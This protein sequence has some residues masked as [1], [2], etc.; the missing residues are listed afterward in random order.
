M[1]KK[2]FFLV[3]L[4]FISLAGNAQK[5]G[6][7]LSGGG[8]KGLTHIG[9]IRALEENGIPID[10]VSG[11]S[12]GAII[13]SLYAMGYSPDEMDEILGSEDFKRWYTGQVEDEYKY[14]FK[15]N[16]PTPEFFS[17]RFGM[18]AQK[19]LSPTGF[20]SM[21]NPIQMNL[22][23]MDLFSRATATCKGNF[24]DL[25]VP[26]RCVASDI[27]N[28]R[29]MILRNGDLGDAVRASMSF[30]FVFKPII[31]NGVKA[32]DGG[33]Y[34]NFP[35]DVM[36]K[37]FHPD[38]ILG[39]VVA[40]DYSQ[41]EE[42]DIMGQMESM[43]MQ[44]T[45]YDIPKKE[46]IVLKFKYPD[47]GLM[48][49]DKI[50][51]LE[52]IGYDS[53]MAHMDS[54][55]ARIQRRVNPDNLRLRRLIFKS[56]MPDLRFKQ[57]NITG[58]TS[59]QAQYIRK[60]LQPSEEKLYTY[61]DVKRAYFRLLSD[62]MFSEI[63]PHAKYDSISNTYDLDLNVKT[64]K[65]LSLR[66]GGNISSSISDQVYFGLTYHDLN[67]YSKEFNI[68]TQVGKIYTNLQLSGRVD[69]NT[70]IPTSYKLIA[71]YSDFD[72]YKNGNVLQKNDNPAF[73]KKS[74]SFVKLKMAIPFLS[75]K[76]AEFG[77]GYGKLDDQYYQTSVIDLG[78]S[79]Q[80]QSYYDLFGGSIV[81]GGST[82]NAKQY[83]NRGHSE[84]IIA[85][86]FTGRE[87][88]KAGSTSSMTN[89]SN[90]YAWLQ[91][92]YK[93]ENYFKLAQHFTLGT[94]IEALYAARN[95][96][97]NY[98]ATK[99]QAG[100]FSPTLHSKI[101]Y[102]EA[103]RANQFGALGIRSLYMP[104]S[105]FQV[106]GEFYIFQPLRSI[107]RDDN[108]RPY[109]GNLLTGFQHIEEVSLVY[110]LPFGAISAYVNHYSSPRN[111]WNVGFSIGWMLFSTRFIE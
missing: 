50:K 88:F 91:L 18:N 77:L 60:E 87:H 58:V 106:R 26:F 21:V 66:M 6:L 62:K 102:N 99:M 27:N 39:S 10:Y 17:I 101:T 12:I 82:L 90:H 7:V 84:W 89:E 57:I 107:K 15:A 97:N 45:N 51:E 29:A 59:Q 28:K 19:K 2:I 86:A 110:R 36:R 42:N 109:Y 72:Y 20:S 95:F 65:N 108:N 1:M 46:G 8:A 44:K 61:E 104:K 74:E 11:T 40:N 68:D 34:N 5:V 76:K 105:M 71:S 79:T 16:D 47:I 13:S 63:I 98:T 69:F 92:S 4:I 96:S 35:A 3:I 48:D 75:D 67:S 32:Y 41:P 81:F 33:I 53:T 37:D 111:N 64:D 14:Y 70:T 100:E 25:F 54:I 43:V 9:V 85:Q 78:N 93:N 30:P 22:V 52:K 83:A 49:F 23:F 31:I 24:D 73:N 80:D 38:V 94:Y 55:K 56:Y 103:F